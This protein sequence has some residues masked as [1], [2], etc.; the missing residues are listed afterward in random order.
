MDLPKI[1]KPAERALLNAGIYNLEEL[2]TKSKAEIAE[3]HGM[4]PKAIGV[5]ENALTDAGLAFA[6]ETA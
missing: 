5:L 3:L 2:A 6:G 1:G 4:G